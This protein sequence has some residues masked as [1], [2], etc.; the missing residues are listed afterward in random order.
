MDTGFPLLLPMRIEHAG[1][2]ARR[3]GVDRRFQIYVEELV[4][5]PGRGQAEENRIMV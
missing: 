1:Q 3:R 4:Q 5:D 2:A